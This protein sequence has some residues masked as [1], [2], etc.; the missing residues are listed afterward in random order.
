MQTILPAVQH[1]CKDGRRIICPQN[2][3]GS[4]RHSLADEKRIANRRYRRALNRVTRKFN[5]DPE[6]FDSEVFNAPSY[7]SWDVC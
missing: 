2:R 6:L 5:T 7:S 4:Y 3:N 1:S